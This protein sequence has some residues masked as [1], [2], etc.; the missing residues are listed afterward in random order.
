MDVF[1]RYF[2]N[3]PMPFAVE[4]IELLVAISVMGALPLATFARGHVAVD[5]V[6]NIVSSR[7]KSWFSFVSILAT[8]GFFCLIGWQLAV[9]GLD[10]ANDGIVTPILGWYIYPVAVFSMTAT[11]AA[12]LTLVALLFG[13]PSPIQSAD[14]W[15]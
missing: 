5:L 13:V 4:L 6:E 7:F 8:L 3:R 10:L 1:G 11:S 9:R 15:E 2:L 12:I 14:D